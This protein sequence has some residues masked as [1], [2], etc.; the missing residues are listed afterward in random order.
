MNVKVNLVCGIISSLIVLGVLIF[1]GDISNSSLILVV[2]IN[3]F[4]AI[5]NIGFYFIIK[6][7][8]AKSQKSEVKE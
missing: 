1:P 5:F 3:L 4:A 6:R 8:Y 7:H 2:S